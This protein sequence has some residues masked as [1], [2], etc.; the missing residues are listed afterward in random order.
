M[1]YP[2]SADYLSWVETKF[3]AGYSNL[4]KFSTGWL[5]I[6]VLVI[7]SFCKGT[8]CGWIFFVVFVTNDLTF[9]VI[10]NPWFDEVFLNVFAPDNSRTAPVLFAVYFKALPIIKD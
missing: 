2:E 6:K 10:L 7:L 3:D 4:A 8:F 9:W 1:A 5:T